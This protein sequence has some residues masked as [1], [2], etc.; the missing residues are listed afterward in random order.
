MKT[1]IA[2]VTHIQPVP[3]SGGGRREK[4]S[5]VFLCNLATWVKKVLASRILDFIPN[6]PEL[7]VNKD[8]SSPVIGSSVDIT[9]ITR[10]GLCCLMSPISFCLPEYTPLVRVH[11]VRCDVC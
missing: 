1:S 2:L 4:N 3:A 10:H 9:S 7:R 8:S 11:A 6:M 5:L